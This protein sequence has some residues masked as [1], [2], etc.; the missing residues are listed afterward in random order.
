M[1]T[2]ARQID[3]IDFPPPRMVGGTTEPNTWI[4]S[5]EAFSRKGLP[6]PIQIVNV[7]PDHEILRKILVVEPLENE[8]CTAASEP[9]VA[10]VLPYLLET[11]ICEETATGLV[12]LA[13]G[14]EWE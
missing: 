10:V 11:K 12:I 8:V 7:E 3:Q 6:P 14:N 9:S 1:P 2:D 4:G 13:A 5:I